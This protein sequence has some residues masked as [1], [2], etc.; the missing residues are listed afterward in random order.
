MIWLSD[1]K[2]LG[3]VGGW[4]NYFTVA[5]SEEWDEIVEEKLNKTDIKFQFT[6]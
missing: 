5:Q 3:G 4:K 2:Y 1:C 6:I